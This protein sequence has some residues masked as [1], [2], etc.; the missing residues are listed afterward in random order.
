M[1]ALVWP[2][3]GGRHRPLAVAP[4]DPAPGE[5]LVAVELA[6]VCG[7]DLH[8]VAGRRPGPAPGVLGHEVVGRV[9]RLGPD[10]VTD[11]RGRRVA[12][13]DRV[14]IG[15][16]AACGTCA[17]CRRGLPHKCARLFKYGHAAL[18]DA[19]PLSG[20]YASHVLVRAGTP[21]AVVPPDLPAALAAPLGCATATAVAVAGAAGDVAGRD[22]TVCGAGL[23]GVLATAM[24]AGRGAS[25]TVLD[26]DPGRR[27]TALRAGAR[28]AAGPDEEVP[29]ADAC[30][31]LSG[32]ADA[33]RRAPARTATGGTIVLAGTVSPGVALDWSAQDVVRGL[34]TVRGVHNYTPADLAGAVAWAESARLP[35]SDVLGTVHPLTD[36]DAALGEAAG[37]TALRVGVRPLEK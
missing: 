3:P 28:H 4:P 37:T 16:Y 36:L 14:A 31:E 17:R 2:G 23:L 10:A 6:T 33:V 21:L 34:L 7:S 26:P 19:G 5:L 15:I 13:G 32:A 1:I 27:A 20:G 29:P 18:A 22:V 30:L 25:V 24:L 8:T 35:V 11:V 12:A 9:V